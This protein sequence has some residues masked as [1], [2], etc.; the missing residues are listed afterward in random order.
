[1]LRSVMR[2]PDQSRTPFD[3]WQTQPNVVDRRSTHTRRSCQKI[4]SR[5]GRQ[6]RDLRNSF[7]P[8]QLGEGFVKK[9]RTIAFTRPPLS[10]R[11]RRLRTR[12]V[13]AYCQVR[14]PCVLGILEAKQKHVYYRRHACAAKASPAKATP[15]SF[16]AAASLNLRALHGIVDSS[17]LESK[18]LERR[19]LRGMEDTGLRMQDDAYTRPP[20]VAGAASREVDKNRKSRQTLALAR[21]FCVPPLS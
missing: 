16:R 11:R 14:S 7:G 2:L 21:R 6:A 20:F 13:Y 1:M 10:M 12:V 4:R 8:Y 17:H 9:L 5:E 3:I 19:N 18:A 15:W